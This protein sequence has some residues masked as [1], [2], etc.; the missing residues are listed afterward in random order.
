MI[1]EKKSDRNKKSN[2]LL[3]QWSWSFADPWLNIL[4]IE[5]IV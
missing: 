4:I 2:D 3:I 5:M 1:Q